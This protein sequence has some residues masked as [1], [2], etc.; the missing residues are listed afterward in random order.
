MRRK[1]IVFYT[2]IF[3]FLLIIGTYYFLYNIYGN[4]IRKEPENIYADPSS[5]ITIE[6]I[7]VNALG[8][9][10]IFRN[11]STMFE[12]IDGRNL[13]DIVETNEAKGILKI[14]S[15]GKIGIVGIKIIS[16]HSLL[17]EY[18]EIQIL[19]LVT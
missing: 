5:E 16:E 6:V 8:W 3:L 15:L 9:K 17:P 13:I 12:I 4:E 19:P 1:I 10:A 18:I 2:S 7:P 14:R 11:S